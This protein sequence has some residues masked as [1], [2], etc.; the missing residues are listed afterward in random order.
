M[1]DFPNRELA[2]YVLSLLGGESKRVHTEDIAAKCHELFPASFSW[3]RYTHFPDKDI[4]RV[5][6]IDA[7]KEQWGALV[8]G[9]SGEGRGHATKTNRGPLLDGWML[10]ETGVQWV[11]DNSSKFESLEEKPR[12][13]PHRQR[14]L[15]ELA[16][17]RSHPLFGTYS[18][19]PSAFSP[20]LGELA[21]FLRCRVDAPDE[22]WM[23]RFDGLRGKATVADQTDVLEF[24]LACR[25]A[26][27]ASHTRADR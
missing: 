25:K 18:S 8:E 19:E 11:R 10:T 24:L 20:S 15:K 12:T 17:L 7:R 27:G 14:I 2:V 1:P 13:K 21:E 4:V 22:V 6:L 9:R 16:R 23:N 26:Y 3:T 5:A